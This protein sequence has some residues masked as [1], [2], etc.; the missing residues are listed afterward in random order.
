[1]KD[2]NTSFLTLKL[3]VRLHK[4]KMLLKLQGRA[5][6]E[7]RMGALIFGWQTAWSQRA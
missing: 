3:Q 7:R 2:L 4:P 1:M 5:E 6:P